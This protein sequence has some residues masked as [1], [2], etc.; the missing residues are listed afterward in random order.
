MTSILLLGS[1]GS[2]GTQTLDLVRQAGSGL[3]V[4]GLA[5]RAS[6]ETLLEQAN[7]FGVTHLA[8]TDPEAAALARPH[9]PP[10]THIHEGPE[11]L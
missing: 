3:T 1:T 9:L 4:S 2:I 8:L 5:A 10:G 7:E 11:A 6:W